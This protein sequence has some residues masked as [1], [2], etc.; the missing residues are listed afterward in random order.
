MFDPSGLLGSSSVS[1][2]RLDPVSSSSLPDGFLGSSFVW[3]SVPSLTLDPVGRGTL[4]R[5]VFDSS[6]LEVLAEK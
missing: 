6:E 1:S 2:Y 4:D 5:V 3:G